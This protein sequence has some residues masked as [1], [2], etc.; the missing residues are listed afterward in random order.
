MRWPKPGD[1]CTGEY[2]II[3]SGT[4]DGKLDTKGVGIVL[5]KTMGNKVKGFVQYNDNIILV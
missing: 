1:F 3:Y 4:E 2:R 5:Q